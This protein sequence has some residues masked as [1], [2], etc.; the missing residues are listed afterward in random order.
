MQLPVLAARTAV[1]ATLLNALNQ[2][3]L[4]RSL[5]AAVGQALD[6]EFD[7][8]ALAAGG[9]ILHLEVAGTPIVRKVVIE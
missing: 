4:H 9:Y 6:A 1:Q 8:R 3:V 7:V 2:T 5:S